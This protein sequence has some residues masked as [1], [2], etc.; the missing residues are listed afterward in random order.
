MRAAVSSQ[1]ALLTTALGAAG[2]CVRALRACPALLSVRK[3][4][5]K[6]EWVTTEN[7]VGAV[8]SSNFAQEA[9]GDVQE[10]FGVLE[11]VKGASEL[12][13]PLSGEVTEI[14]K[15]LAE[16]PGLVNKACYEDGLL[17]K[18]TF[19]NPSELD[20][21]MSEEAYEKYIKSIEG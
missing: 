8:G 12:Y 21:L 9:L 14:N 11:S 15:A 10:E 20:E 6:H 3:F 16:N 18:M 7:G 17:I 1:H 5:E 13:S 4:T 2:G 19:N